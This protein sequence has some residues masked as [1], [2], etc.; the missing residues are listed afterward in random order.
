MFQVTTDTQTTP[1]EKW[2]TKAKSPQRRRQVSTESGADNMVS[3]NSHDLTRNKDQPGVEA[4]SSTSLE[5]KQMDS[6]SL[7]A[8]R[9]SPASPPGGTCAYPR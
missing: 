4:G 2:A 9:M 3:I 5:A 6:L 1:F 8:T 7:V